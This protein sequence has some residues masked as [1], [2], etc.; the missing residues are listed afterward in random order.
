MILSQGKKSYNVET[1]IGNALQILHDKED[2]KIFVPRKRKDCDLCFSTKLPKYLFDWMM[3]Y[4]TGPLNGSLQEGL[5]A[6]KTILTAQPHSLLEVLVDAGIPKVSVGQHDPYDDV[7]EEEENLPTDGSFSSEDFEVITPS[8]SPSAPPVQARSAPLRAEAEPQPRL[9][10]M[11][12]SPPPVFR[13]P[14]EAAGTQYRD[15]IR[16]VVAAGRRA[17]IPSHGAFNM[18]QM[19]ATLAQEVD[20]VEVANDY[21]VLRYRDRM[22]RDRMIGAAGEVFVSLPCRRASVT[23]TDHNGIR[24]SKC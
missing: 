23:E 14:A 11:H 10:V 17:E 13:Q 19:Q 21:F 3:D 15:L 7:E 8:T 18:A 16:R 22:E 6:M 12:A 2:L 4:P 1:S 9:H 5:M 24:S 20:G